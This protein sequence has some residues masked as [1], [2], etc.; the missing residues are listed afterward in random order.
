MIV[1]PAPVVTTFFFA[2]L[3]HIGACLEDLKN[4]NAIRNLSYV[5]LVGGFSS[6]PLV[7]SIAKAKFNRD[8]CTVLAALR[9]DVAIVRGAVLFANNTEVFNTRKAR[10]TYGVLCLEPYNKNDPGHVEHYPE[11]KAILKDGQPRIRA[12][13]RHVAVGD[14][15]PEDGRCQP[16]PYRPHWPSESCV[17]IDILASH[18]KDIRFPNKD[19][20]FKLGRVT[21]PLDMSVPFADRS[22]LVHFNSG[23][24]E[25]SVTAEENVTGR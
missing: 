8:G 6:S 10:L 7:M 3:D 5:F 11:H 19:E 13:S 18:I 16:K 23:G 9:P 1:L 21:V 4:N 20:Y 14:D 15:I 24:T 17:T 22:V 25:L 12:F 2:S